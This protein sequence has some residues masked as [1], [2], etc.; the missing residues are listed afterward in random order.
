MA[1]EQME[2]PQ[3]VD[4]R[5]DIYSLGV[6][7]YEL[8]TNELPL[9]RFAP[10]SHKSA[11]NH[12]LDQIVLQTLEK[13]PADRYQQA[14]QLQAAVSQVD[15]AAKQP[16][17]SAPE[18]R[19]T[20][21]PRPDASRPE[22]SVQK[23]PRRRGPAVPGEFVNENLEGLV[24]HNVIMRALDDGLEIEHNSSSILT[25]GHTSATKTIV[26]PWQSLDSIRCRRGITCDR[27]IIE[28]DSL[29]ALSEVPTAKNSGVTL[30]VKR[31]DWDRGVEVVNVARGHCGLGLEP[32]LN[33][34]V[35]TIYRTQAVMLVAMAAIDV[36]ITLFV[37]IKF[38]DFVP[39]GLLALVKAV[40]NA[41]VI[42][43]AAM[44][45]RGSRVAG[46]VAGIISVIPLFVLWPLMLPVGVWTLVRVHRDPRE[47]HG[48]TP[49][50]RRK[51]Q[52]TSPP[53]PPTFKTQ[54]G[55]YDAKL[56][57]PLLGM[58]IAGVLAAVLLSAT[59]CLAV[60]ADLEGAKMSYVFLAGGLLNIGHVP[61]VFVRRGSVGYL[62]VCSV[63]AMLPLSLCWP[64]SAPCGLWAQIVLHT[65]RHSP[66]EPPQRGVR[67]GWTALI[68][69]VL[70]TAVI[71]SGLLILSYVG[72][73]G[74]RTSWQVKSIMRLQYSED[75]DPSQRD[76]LIAV[77][78]Q[79]FQRA[80]LGRWKIEQFGNHVH[81][82]TNDNSQ[83]RL[84]VRRPAETTGVIQLVRLLTNSE[85]EGLTRQLS[86]PGG[87]KY[88]NDEQS[89]VVIATIA[90]TVKDIE[91][92]IPV[93]AVRD[94]GNFFVVKEKCLYL[95]PNSGITVHY[96]QPT[97]SLEIE[98]PPEHRDELKTWRAADGQAFP[99]A[100]VVDGTICGIASIDAMDTRQS[101][102][103]GGRY[104]LRISSEWAAVINSGPLPAK[105]SSYSIAP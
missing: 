87:M 16:T 20:E 52:S 101:F 45:Y 59:I 86:K 74:V 62:M 35:T 53:K 90:P 38:F 3:S 22:A 105:L 55:E 7:F 75:L 42:V 25:L 79:R 23:E 46:L 19:P 64:L 18:S 11:A 51:P 48:S 50:A 5:A 82:T 100:I 49:P 26:I 77:L 32:P 29:T 73:S 83:V 88:V 97:R 13:D 36:V 30:T 6:V 72:S 61:L 21:A 40:P 8:L 24:Q 103:I 9:G 68:P 65:R 39:I 78:T 34:G 27:I 95:N 58:R 81:I 85:S 70:A 17:D 2:R 47:L 94:A 54:V 31:R 98:L 37:G 28:V 43:S 12:Q 63:L 104:P 15:F 92:L 71:L 14:R 67:F 96:D 4:H 99:V 76:E 91:D 41:V 44:L 57:V 56:V 89:G 102:S 33:D 10:P 80:N 1:P 66:Y 60:F 69:I 93:S 84:T